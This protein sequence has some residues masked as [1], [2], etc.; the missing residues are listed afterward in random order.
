M[1]KHLLIASDGSE[2]GTK[3]VTQGLALA[4]ALG[5]KATVVN[6]TEPWSA[7]LAGDAAVAFPYEDYEKACA[8]SAATILDA[9]KATAKDLGVDVKA[10]HIQD[11]YPAE[12]IISAA[13]SCG[14]D[15]I[16]M[17]SHGRK[18]LTRIL[19]G[20]QTNRVVTHTELPVLVCR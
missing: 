6:V 9:A 12:G 11:Q 14:A 2:L 7:V 13:A 8:A 1:Y 4:K 20:S 3:A 10:V 19:L 16:V 17:A 15:L 18:G 5:A